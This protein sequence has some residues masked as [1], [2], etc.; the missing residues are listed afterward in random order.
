[1]QRTQLILMLSVA[2]LAAACGGDDGGSS[3]A[4]NSGADTG[5]EDTGG[6]NDT[7]AADDTGG[8]AD[9]GG[10]DDTGGGEHVDG[11]AIPGLSATTTVYIDDH[12][13]PHIEAANDE[14]AARAMGWLHARDRFA[15]MDLRRRLTTGRISTLVGA[16]AVDL[17]LTNRALFTT[18]E[19]EP[20]EDALLAGATPKTV[21]LLEAYAEGVNAWL[22][23]LEDGYND[24]RLADEYSF[25]LVNRDN[26]PPWRPEDSLATIAA[27][28]NSLTNKS[29]AELALGEVYA[30]VDGE[31][32]EDLFQ[33]RSVTTSTILDDFTYTGNKGKG[34]AGL[35]LNRELLRKALPAL[36]EAR[37]RLEASRLS[38]PDAID[39]LGSNNWVV[40]PS[41]TANGKALLSNDPHLGLSNPSIWY[42]AHMDA[43]TN[44][45]GTLHAA[46]MSFAGMPW[47]VIGQNEEIAWGATN[48]FFDQ[49]DVYIE[50]LTEDG[51]GVMIDGEAVPFV[52]REYSFEPSGGAARTETF[53]W[54]PQHGPVLSID[55]EAGTAVTLKWTGNRMTTDANLLTELMAANDIGQARDA[56]R[57]VTS[58][59]QC[60]VV[61]DR[62]GS[63]GWFPYNSVPR[64]PWATLEQPSWIPLPGDGSAEWDGYF[65][66][67]ELPQALNPSAGYLATANNDMTGEHID[68]DPTN[69]GWPMFQ[70]FVA[71]GFR[72]EQI[73][74]RLTETN[75][76]TVDTMLDIVGDNTSLLGEVLTPVLLAA[77]DGAELPAPAQAVVDALE[78]WDYS[79]PS[80]L[81]G[82]T[83]DADP[84]D[85]PAVAAASAGCTAFHVAYHDIRY[86]T[87][88]DEHEANAWS[89]YPSRA[90]FLLA[91]LRP[92]VLNTPDAWW[93]DVSTDDTTETRADVIVRGLTEAG[94]FL[95]SEL[96]ADP[97]GWRWGR[98]H[99][100][101]L[102]ADLFDAF[103]VADY[104]NPSTEGVAWAND[105][106][107]YTVDVANTRNPA[108][109]DYSHSA[110]PSM[111]MVCE[112]GDPTV[113]CKVQL[114]G[115]QRHFRDSDNYDD[116]LRK[117][118]VNE[119]IDLIFSIDQ[120]RDD[121][122]ATLTFSPE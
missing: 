65:D 86:A 46:G 74:N 35:T 52:E 89:A 114:P 3:A 83:A 54:V 81:D 29:A 22:A 39:A 80:G 4:S 25:A 115:G 19:G 58:I 16:V 60:W 93:D 71:T 119:P 55:E 12:G 57:N 36:T 111:R 49:S 41:L 76:H 70:T 98:L 118:L 104:N 48:T 14:D 20:L 69:D 122:A 38:M 40:A 63:I 17:D 13:I 43:R 87:F 113:Q 30:Q 62:Q 108:E 34:K 9:T 24:A 33:P 101:T 44:G 68:G 32:A 51:S 37:E 121:A 77:V 90:A 116:L 85:D 72:H 92:E 95:N 26:I 21:A 11:L 103:G 8:V 50:T 2:L 99:T 75:Q 67:D 120:I 28:V 102:R 10:G 31:L 100:L 61:I 64:R 6:A 53:R 106:G 107:D 7:G 47:I 23:D 117:W 105:G 84:I 109:R 5:V 66:L 110:G 78:G 42:M 45:T 18:P 112:A 82:I 79:C 73:V 56:I 97:D 88:D 15:Q 27:L 96:G 59:G 91:M 1:M 94:R